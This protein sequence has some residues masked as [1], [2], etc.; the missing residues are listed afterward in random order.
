MAERRGREA[1]PAGYA[2][3][4]PPMIHVCACCVCICACCVCICACVCMCVY[5]CDKERLVILLAWCE[6]ASSC[7]V[8]PSCRYD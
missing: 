7:R 3:A 4:T 8:S 2:G 5:A 6:C 1:G